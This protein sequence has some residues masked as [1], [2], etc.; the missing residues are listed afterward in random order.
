MPEIID[1]IPMPAMVIAANDELKATNA[2][3]R[4]LF[5]DAR[6][7]RSYLT[8][9]RQPKFVALIDDLRENRASDDS[10]IVISDQHHGAFNVTGA[11]LDESRLLICLQDTNETA[12]AVQMR[13]NFI[14]DLGHELRT[15]LTAISGILET[16]EG[17]IEALSR[18]LPLMSGEV[19]RMTRLVSDLLALSR[20]EHNAHRLPDEEVVLQAAI[21]AASAPLSALAAQSEMRIEFDLP[22]N[23]LRFQGDGDEIV[24]AIGNLIANALRYGK[25]G[26]VVKVRA[27]VSDTG[28]SDGVPDL[29][30]VVQDDGPGVEPHHIPRL[31]ERFYRVDD[32]RSRDTGGSGLGLAIVKHIANRHRGRMAIESAP[33]AGLKVT[34]RL[35]L[36]RALSDF[37][38]HRTDLG[39]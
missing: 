35:P 18:F 20:V 5:P 36:R 10:E 4:A 16:C 17:D 12:S 27:R 9:L 33:G 3:F 24:R 1:A 19:D 31:A 14:A 37:S 32:H 2:P 8:I 11:R 25:R 23:P 7:G 28:Q 30:L 38:T 6:I 13:S 15:P 34:L 29:L 21:E 26:G 39:V 22:D